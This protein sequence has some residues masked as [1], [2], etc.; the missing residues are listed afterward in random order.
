MYTILSER[1]YQKWPSWAV[2]YEWEDIFSKELQCNI[3]CIGNSFYKRA[4]NIL[5]GLFCK[6]G[7]FVKKY[8][9]GDGIKR[10][11]FVMEADKYYRLPM[12]NV[13]PVFLDF[14]VCMIDTIIRST[15]QL[16]VFFV[17]CKDIYDLILDRGITNV[18]YIPLSVPDI[19][20]DDSFPEKTIDVIQ[21]GRKDPV[22]HKYM[23][24]YCNENAE[25][26]Y[27]YQTDDGTM[28]YYSTKRGLIGKFVKRSEYIKLI[29]SA[30]I[31][32]VSSP[33][34]DRK[35]KGRFGEIDFITPRFYESAAMYCHMLG[36]Y[37]DNSEA[38]ETGIK[39][40]CKNIYDYEDFCD[41]INEYL[42][43]TVWDWS[44][45]RL[46][47]DRNKTSVRA[48]YVKNI[49]DVRL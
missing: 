38:D 44:K 37:T 13:I 46:F 19:Y 1:N 6:K 11:I 14:P 17:T 27:V 5:N 39:E 10:L 16:P 41:S 48:E 30:K 12:K 7:F 23:L 34:C 2:V 40:I 31:S 26:E 29:G 8:E 21:F 33:G 47:I 3:E 36:R 42:G 45:Q 18:E 32:L 28:E 4:V 24:D 22:L 15:S 35:R 25:V 20:V 43:N 9:Y 49:L